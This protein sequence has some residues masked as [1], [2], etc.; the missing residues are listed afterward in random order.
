MDLRLQNRYFHLVMEHEHVLN[1]AASGLSALPGTKQSFSSTQA[2]YRFLA[3]ENVTLHALIEPIRETACPV[4]AQT[5]QRVALIAHDWSML[6]YGGHSSKTDRF[7]RSHKDDLGYELAVA[8]LIEADQGMPLGPME[9][10]LR[11]AHGVLTTRPCGA[12]AYSSRL[13]ELID[14]MDA[15]RSWRLNRTLVHVIDR[16]ADSVWH[17]RRWHAAGH[18][19]VVRADDQR[20]VRRNGQRQS[21]PEVAEALFIEGAFVDSGKRIAYEEASDARLMIAETTIVLDRPAKR[22]IDGRK[23]DIPGEPLTLRLVVCRVVDGEGKLLARWLLLTNVSEIDDAQTI[24]QWYYWR[25]RI[26]TYYKLLKSAGQQ[27][28]EWEQESGEA[29]AKRLAIASMA[30]LT[31][32]VLQCDKSVGAGEFRRILIRLSGRQMKWNVE[33]TAPALLSGLEKLLAVLNLLEEYDTAY[34]RSLLHCTLPFLPSP[35]PRRVV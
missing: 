13:D 23:V 35:P 26:E 8:L 9:I 14:V 17:Y 16:E 32:W 30:C 3:N 34:L 7:Q 4:L 33:N 20:I 27:I 22:K 19:F 21:L 1:A 15:S 12:K 10:R 28:E 24:V 5:S 6:S 11:N 18:Q 29:I 25:W 2:M 31:V